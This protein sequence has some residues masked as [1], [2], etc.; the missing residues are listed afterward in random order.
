[1]IARDRPV[2]FEIEVT[3]AMIEAGLEA[4]WAH[5]RGEDLSRDVVR[6]VFLAMQAALCGPTREASWLDR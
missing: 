2:V 4:L 3:P 5:E 6:D 1:M